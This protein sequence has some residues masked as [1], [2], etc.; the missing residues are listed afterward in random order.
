[1]RDEFERFVRAFPSQPEWR[2]PSFNGSPL[3]GMISELPN[4]LVRSLP[5]LHD[6]YLIRG[7]IGSGGWTHTPWLAVLDPAVTT[8]VAEG[9]YLVY[10]LSLG[11]ERL[12][13]TLNQGCSLLADSVGVRPARQTLLERAGIMRSRILDKANRLGPISL[14][15]NVGGTVWRGKLYE[16]G[17]VVA[18][19]YDTSALPH[20]DEMIAD[21]R[22]GLSLYELL[23]REGGWDP[24]DDIA[25]VAID[26][27]IAGKGI[28]QAKRY[29]QHRSIERQSSHSKAVKKR[30]GDR[31]RGCDQRMAEVY[32]AIGE[33]MIDAHHLIPLSSLADGQSITFD[34]VKDFAV[35]C[36][37]CHRIIHRLPDPS[38]LEALRQLVAAAR[39]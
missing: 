39:R 27:G 9:Y 22:E 18:K 33:G 10:L 23:A 24:A 4:A 28:E 29:R 30:Q 36:P 37:N 25:Q 34:P 12:Y 7:S 13:L 21:L 20:R 35:L 1:M 14:D 11:A 6:R 3:H 26:D 19:V 38:D 8:R 2:D 5:E 31:C 15:L 17:S 16:A 32:G